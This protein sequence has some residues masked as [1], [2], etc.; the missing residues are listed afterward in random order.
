MNPLFEDFGYDYD[1]VVDGFDDPRLIPGLNVAA[2]RPPLPEALPGALS[3]GLKPSESDPASDEGK[4]N[5]LSLTDLLN[6]IATQGGV[7]GIEVKTENNPIGTVETAGGSLTPGPNYLKVDFTDFAGYSA[8]PR[9][10][11]VNTDFLGDDVGDGKGISTGSA[12]A[13]KQACQ[14]NN[15]CKFWS[16]RDGWA[17][18]CYLK[19]GRRGDP[20]PTGAIPKIGYV[21]GTKGNDDC[22]C[23]PNGANSD[24]EICPLKSSRPVFPWKNVDGVGRSK[25]KNDKDR[26][27]RF[28]YDD[29]ELGLAV[30]GVDDGLPLVEAPSGG[31]GPNLQGRFDEYE[32]FGRISENS[33]SSS[34]NSRNSRRQ[35]G[36]RNR[37]SPGL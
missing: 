10:S 8:I 31:D 3:P 15:V 30:D 27:F 18:D 16:F 22:L 28:D 13:C 12:I 32:D 25:D 37:P 14:E 5:Q 11:Y 4:K 24:E 9:C 19:R 36:R 17:R 35:S 26:P 6:S 23:L 34:S 7:E 21:S 33:S 20:N 1:L 2:R 29:Y